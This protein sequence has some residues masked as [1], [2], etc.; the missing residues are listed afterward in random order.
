MGL[1]YLLKM[2]GKKPSRPSMFRRACD[3]Y[4]YGLKPC[5]GKAELPQVGILFHAQ[6]PS[7]GIFINKKVEFRKAKTT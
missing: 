2:T 7:L 4:L 6:F 3:Y 5:L 1:M